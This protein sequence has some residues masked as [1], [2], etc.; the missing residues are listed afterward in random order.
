MNQINL[1]IVVIIS[2]F[3]CS[4]LIGSTVGGYFYYIN[5]SKETTTQQEG[6]ESIPSDFD[7]SKLRNYKIVPNV[8]YPENDIAYFNGKFKNCPKKCDLTPNCIGYTL[9]KEKGYGCWLKTSFKNP[10]SSNLKDTFYIN[11]Q[12]PLPSK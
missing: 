4:L 1:L 11:E 5:L 3:V 6:D 7:I 8:D 10:I 12:P 9:N 2:I